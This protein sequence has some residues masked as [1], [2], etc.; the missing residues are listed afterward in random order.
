ML[1]VD[2][3]KDILSVLFVAKQTQK[4]EKNSIWI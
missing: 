2:E 3:L 4:N 1:L